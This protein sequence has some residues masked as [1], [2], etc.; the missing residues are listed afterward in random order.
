M[1]AGGVF[2]YVILV[3]GIWHPKT[4]VG[5]LT[6]VGRHASV[7]YED[8]SVLDLTESETDLDIL[9]RRR[10]AGWNPREFRQTFIMADGREIEV[11]DNRPGFNDEDFSSGSHLMLAANSQLKDED[12]PPPLDSS[13]AVIL[14]ALQVDSK[15]QTVKAEIDGKDRVVT[16]D[17]VDA[18]DRIYLDPKDA[19]DAP[20]FALSTQAGRVDQGLSLMGPGGIWGNLRT[21]TPL[22]N[23]PTGGPITD[24]P[25]GG[26]VPEPSTWALLG[27]AGLVAGAVGACRHRQAA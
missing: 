27:L 21:T 23:T 1:A 15:D 19:K 8:G 13:D 22:F 14:A 12:V 3:S 18:K 16:Q 20:V 17:M 7:A 25:I 5:G 6:Q 2:A 24:P 11:L 26:A 4:P 9:R 10:L